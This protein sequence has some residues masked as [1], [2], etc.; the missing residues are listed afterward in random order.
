MEF[1]T[2]NIG[3][4]AVNLE[5]SPPLGELLPPSPKNLAAHPSQRYPREEAR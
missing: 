1:I 4:D 3:F 5:N 2:L